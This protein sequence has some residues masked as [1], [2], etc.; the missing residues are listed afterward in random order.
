MI[1]VNLELANKALHKRWIYVRGFLK[2]AFL[3]DEHDNL[4][5]VL[6]VNLTHDLI[7]LKVKNNLIC[8]FRTSSS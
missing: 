4:K 1:S 5:Q 7:A 6:R 3:W 8:S 2:K